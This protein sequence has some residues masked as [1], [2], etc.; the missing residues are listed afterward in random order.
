MPTK[1]TPCDLDA[2]IRH[3]Q[4]GDTLYRHQLTRLSYTEGVRFMAFEAE[5]CW[6]IDAI[7]SSQ[8]I[9][10]VSA[11]EFQVWRLLVSHDHS[12]R[13]VMDDG[14]GNVIHDQVIPYTDFPL[15]E[16]RLYF[17]NGVLLLP[18]ER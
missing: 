13:L 4:P 18:S 6:L 10:A 5:A 16:V 12:A 17:E 14:N 2:Q 9:P 1:L 8:I 11:E 3:Y 15:A 7:L